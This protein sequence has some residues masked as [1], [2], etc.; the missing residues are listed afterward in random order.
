[1][2]Q[3]CMHLSLNSRS[4]HDR[5]MFT[6]RL[7]MGSLACK[8][9]FAVMQGAAGDGDPHLRASTALMSL[10]RPRSLCEIA[11]SSAILLYADFRR[12]S[13]MLPAAHTMFT[14]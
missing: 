14:G 12:A 9:E 5:S 3:A 11:G 8:A 7:P 4:L 2:K 13:C 6:H 10:L 1:M